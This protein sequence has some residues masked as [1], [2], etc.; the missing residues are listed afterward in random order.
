MFMQQTRG[1]VAVGSGRLRDDKVALRNAGDA[2]GREVDETV[3]RIGVELIDERS[4][5]WPAFVGRGGADEAD[6]DSLLLGVASGRR[7]FD[8]NAHE[9]RVCMDPHPRV[10]DLRPQ[11]VAFDLD[12]LLV[13]TEE[14]YQDV[15]T[16]LL[17]RRGRE[18]TA[19]LLDRM[20][21]RPQHVALQIMI[22]WHGLSD[23]IETL[24]AETRAIFVSLLDTRLAPMPGAVDLLA[25][26]A[27]A[28]IPRGVATSS[29][30]E[31][32][33][34]VLG[35]LGLLG[36]FAFVLTSADVVVAE[37]STPSLGV[38]FEIASAIRWGKRVL[39]LYRVQE[40]RKLS[41]M[42]AGCPE[43]TVSNYL[44]M[45]DIKTSISHFINSYLEH[46]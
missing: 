39:C 14:L 20:M 1:G 15:G 16:E 7:L 46:V 26:L 28:G 6:P 36:Q 44:T 29:G 37:V 19:D 34:E 33:S 42:I 24:A 31:F 21:G 2:A 22:D 41:A 23:T 8:R 25:A 9:L 27:A 43:V 30:P 32:A 17:R 35:R 12:G 3:S 18:F 40:D 10:D 45:E 5:D 4:V 38:G 13:N 11:A